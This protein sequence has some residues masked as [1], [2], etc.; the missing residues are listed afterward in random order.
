LQSLLRLL[1]K[2]PA[3]TQ[4]WPHDVLIDLMID[5]HE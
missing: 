2:L 3:L 5:P 4:N 1:L